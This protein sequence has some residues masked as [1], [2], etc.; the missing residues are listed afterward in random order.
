[1]RVL[2]L[3]TA[4]AGPM[5]TR[6]LAFLGADVIRVENPIR[7]DSWR[8]VVWGGD[9][10]SYPDGDPGPRPYNRNYRFNAVNTDKRSIALDLR[11][12]QARE[13][14]LQLALRC[15]V[16]TANF[17]DGVLDRLGLGY[18]QLSARRPDII[19]V[20]MPAYGSGGTLTNFLGMGNTMEAMAG[21]TVMMGYGDG[22]PRMTG[23]FYLDPM[24]GL[25]AAAAVLTA[26]AHRRRT[27]RGQHI[28][29]AQREAALHWA[30]ELLLQ[31]IEN[32]DAFEPDG[33]MVPDAAP[34]DAYP[35]LG[36]DE[37]VAIA[38]SS[39]EQWWALAEVIGRP[40]LA[41][42]PRFAAFPERWRNRELLSEPL[43]AWTS[44]MRK[45]E[46]ASVLQARGVPAA[47]VDHGGDIA[48]SRYL[49]ER[50]F[51]AA[52]PHPEAGTHSYAGL[53][54]RLHDTPGGMRTAAPCFGQH[55]DEV[56]AELLGFKPEQV[57]ELERAGVL[58]SAPQEA[59][60]T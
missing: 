43:T 60:S 31:Q 24:G 15:D 50:G 38:V 2:D 20:E 5:A 56:L 59:D 7:I 13:I 49:Q 28:E 30:G 34:H 47:P 29:V 26:L 25:H 8:G 51:F 4:W 36:D 44:R 18:A 17:S 27:G 3:T 35:C 52:L 33:N 22:V 37:W 45:G 54:F 55:N 23:T 40:D 32:G 14:A 10:A 39:D 11:R 41:S 16:V 42:D 46:A 1:V 58:V 48:S 21:M 9:A 57:A 6:C 12:P 19:V 53:A